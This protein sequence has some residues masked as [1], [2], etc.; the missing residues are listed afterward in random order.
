[1][2]FT[3]DDHKKA[4]EYFNQ[5]IAIDPNFALAYSGLADT[6]GASSTN[7]WISPREG[8]P[9]GMIAAKRALELDDSLAEAHA[10]SGALSMFYNLEWTSAERDY[11][12]AIELN[13]NYEI[14]YELYSYLLSAMGKLD[15]A[16]TTAQR[17]LDAAPLSL[18]LSEDLT[19][20]YY[21]ARRYDESTRAAL[22]SLEIEP[23]NFGPYLR[24]AEIYE[25]QRMHDAAIQQCQ[26]AIGLVGRRT[27]LLALMGHAYASSG[28]PQ[29]ALK[30]LDELNA[31]SKQEYVSSYDLA[32]LYVGLAD[33]DRAFEQLNK[34]YDDRAGWIIYLNVEPIFDPIRSDPRFGELVKRLKLVS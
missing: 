26:K 9:K 20:A 31:K 7:G 13:P 21:L 34:A 22:K 1:L 33:K 25:V 28:R 11:K 32:I 16:V 27:P 3:P 6:Y 18:P 4:A 24:L 19:G 10:T 17:G 2:K 30:I 29:E 14:S 5:A 8:Y 23:N 12:R 15:Q